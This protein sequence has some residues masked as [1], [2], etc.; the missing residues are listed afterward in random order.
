MTLPDAIDRSDGPRRIGVSIVNYNSAH[1]LSALIETL[2]SPHIAAISIV[3]NSGEL[4][5]ERLPDLGDIETIVVTPGENLGFGRGQNLSCA[6]LVQRPRIEF[7][8]I[9]NPDMK[10]TPGAADAL[11]KAAA[12]RKSAILS[13]LITT[14]SAANSEVCWFAGGQMDIKRGNV[15]HDGFGDPIASWTRCEPYPTGFITGAAPFMS[16]SVWE[17]LGGFD[18]RI[19]L[20]WEDVDLSLRA[21]AQGVGLYVVPGS[22]VWHLESGSSRGRDSRGRGHVYTINNA[23]NRTRLMARYGNP[24]ERSLRVIW[25]TARAVAS[26]LAGRS[27]PRLR[28]AILEIRGS[29]LGWRDWRTA[30]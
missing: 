3:D 2:R 13:P 21:L 8:W 24:G 30:G 9:L 18:D 1:H 27:R 20:Y 29:L 10:A 17:S 15:S 28:S 14:T 11:L 26:S 23:R 6:Q 12:E 16:V 5:R 19:F 7:I 22:V 4:D 25:R